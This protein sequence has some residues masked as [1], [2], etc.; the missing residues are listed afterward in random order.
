MQMTH[1]RG[2]VLFLGLLAAGAVPGVGHERVPTEP[3]ANPLVGTVVLDAPFSA[4]AITTVRETLADGTQVER[5]GTAR[6]YRDR[7]GRVRVEQTIVGRSASAADRQIRVT[8]WSP[9]LIAGDEMLGRNR[10]T[11]LDWSTG[12]TTR[13][14]RRAADRAS[15]PRSLLG[16]V[17]RSRCRSAAFV[18]W[19]STGITDH[20]AEAGSTTPS[21]SARPSAGNAS[22]ASTRLGIVSR[23]RFRSGKLATIGR[24][25]LWTSDG[26]RRN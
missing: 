9:L 22:R 18:S 1:V 4:D 19:C 21:S 16:V 8:V 7:A 24:S 15:P 3:V 25:S 2:V 5:I 20:W 12:S 6:L 14:G 10:R 11:L 13:H 23:G 26:N 17:T